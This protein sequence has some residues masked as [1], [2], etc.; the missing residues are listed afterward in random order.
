MKEHEST[1]AAMDGIARNLIPALLAISFVLLGALPYQI[2]L[3]GPIFP[4]LT[5]IVV[6]FWSIYRPELVPPA[7]VFLIGFF[8]DILT[9]APLGLSSFVLLLVHGVVVNQRRVFMGKPFW[10]AWMGF[11]MVAIGTAIGSWI[12]ASIYNGTFMNA[13]ALSIQLVLTISIYPG[14]SWMFSMIQRIIPQPE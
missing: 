6:Y 9:G 5:L 4:A 1:L 12:I 3:L 14:F 11:A 7:A 10:V 13:G 2:P 8:Q